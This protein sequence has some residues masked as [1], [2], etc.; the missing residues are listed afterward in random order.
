MEPIQEVRRL[1]PSLSRGEKAQVLKWLFRRWE[2]ISLV[3]TTHRT[4]A[5][6]IPA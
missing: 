6:A 5:E 4:P 3:S 1:L 2:T